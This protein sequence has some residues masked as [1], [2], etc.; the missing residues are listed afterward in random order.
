M[1]NKSKFATQKDQNSK[2]G[3]RIYSKLLKEGNI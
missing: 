2:I 3:L 1:V